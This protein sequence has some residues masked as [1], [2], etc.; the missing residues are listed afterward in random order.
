MTGDESYHAHC[1]TCRSCSRRIE[2]LVFAK[3][4]QGIYC[5][6]CHN[7][8]VAKSR[9]H[10][11]A[12]RNRAARKEREKEKERERERERESQEAE[13]AQPPAQASGSTDSSPLAV[14]NQKLSSSVL[15]SPNPSNISQFSTPAAT[16]IA[17]GSGIFQEMASRDGDGRH[18]VTSPLEFHREDGESSRSPS[19]SRAEGKDRDRLADSGTRERTI[20]NSGM[21]SSKL[22]QE[23]LPLPSSPSGNLSAMRRKSFDESARPPASRASPLI[24]HTQS[25]SLGSAP[26][27]GEDTIQNPAVPRSANVGLGVGP[28][29]L[30]VPMTKAERRRSINPG[31]TFN[32]EAEALKADGRLTPLPP[33]PLRASFTEKAPVHKLSEPRTPTS[34]SSNPFNNHS[35]LPTVSTQPATPRRVEKELTEQSLAPRKSSLPDQISALAKSPGRPDGTERTRTDSPSRRPPLGPRNQSGQS[36][37]SSNRDTPISLDSPT[38]SSGRQT[39]TTETFDFSRQPTPSAD[40]DDQVIAPRIDAPALPPMSFSLSDPDF[41]LLLNDIHVTP[42]DGDKNKTPSTGSTIKVDIAA[43]QLEADKAEPSLSTSPSIQRSPQMSTLSAAVNGEHSMLPP[44]IDS[45]GRLYESKGDSP[46]L[47]SRQVSAESTSSTDLTTSAE[48]V[49]PLL[50]ALLSSAKGSGQ[51]SIE[52]DISL[53]EGVVKELDDFSGLVQTLKVKYNGARRSSQ[54]YSEG[55][56]V[57]G[58]EY[59]KEVAL[60]RD[61]EAEVTRLRA[62]LHGQTA[63]LSVISGDERRQETMRRRSH[64]L[65]MNLSGLEKDISKLR[66]QRDISLAEV[67]ELEASK[68]R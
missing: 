66:A 35:N 33:S 58:E 47:R 5:M 44:R 22:R 65:A 67:E 55:L 6:A 27:L 41:A 1:F 51:S 36:A 32:L 12:K 17:S 29:G 61:A 68:A 57:A 16:P 4:S 48:S 30:G 52:I 28:V 8:R 46:R 62:A 50:T 21:S 59:D 26:T 23:T 19:R 9:R 53:L 25:P 39:P 34:P 63:R 10:A 45:R 43:A 7:E 13:Q 31:M 40:G 38:R 54:Q 60:R 3:T 64:D 42:R 56:N 24:N 11:E 49:Q 2:E 18:A 20:S 15:A 37:K 14:S